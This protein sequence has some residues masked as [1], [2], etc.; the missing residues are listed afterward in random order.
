MNEDDAFFEML[1]PSS[2]RSGGCPVLSSFDGAF[3]DPAGK[4]AEGSEV[5]QGHLL[6]EVQ[7]ILVGGRV[8]D[9]LEAPG[10]EVDP[11][12]LA[13]AWTAWVDPECRVHTG[14]VFVTPACR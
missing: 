8:A 1:T 12:L 11:S 7:S 13:A 6:G 9:A 10:P 14:P 5:L 4:D 2:T 3:V